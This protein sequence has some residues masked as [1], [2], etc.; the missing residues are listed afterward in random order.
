MNM[1]ISG[2]PNVALK[3]E[4]EI[5]KA[6][7]EPE[8]ICKNCKWWTQQS[9]YSDDEWDCYNDTIEGF[10]YMC[11]ELGGYS[12]FKPKGDFGCNQWEKRG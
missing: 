5:K 9:D 4:G 6:I 10:V 7:N 11:T 12:G 3:I 8:R 1:K 2:A